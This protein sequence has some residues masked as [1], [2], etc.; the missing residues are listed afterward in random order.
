MKEITQNFSSKSL[1]AKGSGGG[2][3]FHGVLS[4]GQHAAIKML[5][6]DKELSNQEFVAQ[7]NLAITTY[8]LIR[9]E[10]TIVMLLCFT[11]L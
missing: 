10:R 1:I 2:S 9:M 3:V 5:N 6:K 11:V 7:V 8:Q 4:T